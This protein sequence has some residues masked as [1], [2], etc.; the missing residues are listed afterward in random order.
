MKI[1][2]DVFVFLSLS[3]FKNRFFILI[4]NMM[5]Y[6]YEMYLIWCFDLVCIIKINIFCFLLNEKVI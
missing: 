3:I 6:N 1:K 2:V 5:R 4:N